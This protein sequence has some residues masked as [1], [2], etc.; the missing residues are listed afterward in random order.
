MAAAARL[1]KL[2]HAVTVLER[3]SAA[4]GRLHAVEHEGFRWDAGPSST[5]LPAALRDLFRKSGRPIER[6]L[7]LELR[8]PARR[9]VFADGSIVDLPTGSRA[10]QIHAVDCGLGAGAGALWSQFVDDLASGWEQFRLSAEGPD[11]VGAFG[12]ASEPPDG[13]DHDAWGQRGRA[14]GSLDRLLRRGLPDERLRELVGFRFA[15]AGSKLRSVPASCVDGVYVERSFGVWGFPTGSSALT[16]ALVTRLAERNVEVLYDSAVRHIRSSTSGVT[17][18]ELEDGSLVAASI[19]VAAIDPLVVFTSLLGKPGLAP[20]RVFRSAARRAPPA[21]VH[22]GLR[23]DNPLGHPGELVLHGDPLVTVETAGSAPDG[24]RAWTVRLPATAST[25]TLELLAE[26]G[27]DVRDQVVARVDRP[28]DRMLAE[29][30]EA[31]YPLVWDGLRSHQKR[32]ASAHPVPGLY[33]LAAPLAPG[34]SIPEVAWTAAHVAT[35]VGKA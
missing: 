7:R 33:V 21:A 13:R 4:G 14:R 27:L 8:V 17:G 30:G 23:G 10:D 18:V 28:P 26:R 31:A 9:H 32:F 22:L 5:G 3:G 6:Y 24:H 25:H 20:A 16:D 2:G 15:V 12:G 19:V 35:A 29:T 11:G 34:A 1:A